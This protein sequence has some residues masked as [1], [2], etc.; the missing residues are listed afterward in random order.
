MFFFAIIIHCN[1]YIF[2]ETQRQKIKKK[3][4]ELKIKKIKEDKR[5]KKDHSAANILV[6]NLAALTLSYNYFPLIFVLVWASGNTKT[7]GLRG[8]VSFLLIV[9]NIMNKK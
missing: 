5:I 7:F 6:I 1:R 4:C 2:S 8:F 3:E 9:E